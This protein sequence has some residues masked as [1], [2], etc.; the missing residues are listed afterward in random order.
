MK[1]FVDSSTIIALSRIGELEFLREFFGK[2]RITQHIEGE[3][4]NPAHPETAAIEKAL[5]SWMA[6]EKVKG[7][8]TR[9]SKYGLGDGE[10][11]L[12]LTDASDFLVLDELSARKLAESEGRPFSGLLGLILSAAIEGIIDKPKA[13]SMVE[14]LSE[15]SFRMSTML[16]KD[17]IR[18]INEIPDK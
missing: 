12:F 8:T 3:I 4:L 5:G 17:M 9:F 2:V 1:V 16:Y 15:S 18:K 10:S 14:R 13:L 6:V 11:S 7:A